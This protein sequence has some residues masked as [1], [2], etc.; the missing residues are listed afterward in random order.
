MGRR[1][2]RG[3]HGLALLALAVLATGCRPKKP[4]TASRVWL[5]EGSGCV[6]LATPTVGDLSCWGDNSVGQLG[7]GT[8][9]PH[10]VAMRTGLTNANLTSFA[11]GDRH[12]CSVRDA[13]ALEC[14]GDPALFGQPSGPPVT[15]PMTVAPFGAAAPPKVTVH[16]GGKHT[17]WASETDVVCKGAN[18]EGQLGTEPWGVGAP[19]LAVALGQAHTCVAYGQGATKASFVR[20]RGR[21]SAAPIEDILSDIPLVD[22]SAGA[23]HTCAA[24]RD[25]TVRC[26]GK[27]TDGQLGDGTTNDSA[28]PVSI[29]D[30]RGI[31]RVSVGG[32]HSCGLIRNGTVACWGANEH[33]QLANGKT[34]RSARPAVIVGLVGV[35]EVAAA[36]DGACALL[37]GGYVR[38]WG[39]N[40]RG[41][42]GSGGVEELN[43]PMQIRYR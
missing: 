15:R 38:C 3:A 30:F 18:D 29:P 11:M 31:A 6:V 40:D 23:E 9:T 36:G 33:H 43:V 5:G 27:N 16:I 37:D 10:P 13:S 26:W 32:R 41:Q 20:C 2:A 12:T 7:D 22:L 34:D 17:C 39:K 25:G 19:V 4:P 24:L 35:R 14:W 42:L 28:S 1:L 8:L 21:K